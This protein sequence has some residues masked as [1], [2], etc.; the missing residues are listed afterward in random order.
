MLIEEVWFNLLTPRLIQ[1]AD[2][3]TNP[4]SDLFCFVLFFLFTAPPATYGNSQ[5]RGQVGATAAGLHYSHGNTASLTLSEAKDHTC[6]LTDTML[7]S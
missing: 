3:W 6:I 2:F 7:G 5:I 4:D 1:E